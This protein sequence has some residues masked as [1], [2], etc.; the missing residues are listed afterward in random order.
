MFLFYLGHFSLNNYFDRKAD[1]TNERKKIYNSWSMNSRYLKL[2]LIILLTIYWVSSLI[3]SVFLNNRNNFLFILIAIAIFFSIIY[4]TPPIKL[5]GKAPFDLILDLISFGILA[6]MF[7]IE[8]FL[9]PI[10]MQNYFF[11]L[12]YMVLTVG[13]V[14]LPT[15]IMDTTNDK[16]NGLTTFSVRYG[17]LRTIKLIRILYYLQVILSIM[18]LV[19]FTL[20]R[21]YLAIFIMI[22]FL[23]GE[24]VIF[25]DFF[26]KIIEFKTKLV[27]GNYTEMEKCSE[28]MVNRLIASLFVAGIYL[29]ALVTILNFLTLDMN[30]LINELFILNIP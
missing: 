9:I 1:S 29:F 16:N 12:L 22:M 24:K 13:I 10:S 19:I 15:I 11:L 26:N 7:V 25:G 14:V 4:S 23:I 8:I 3:I 5:K 18:I 20:D 30:Q 27:N 6:P 28:A 17:I 21:N 2:V